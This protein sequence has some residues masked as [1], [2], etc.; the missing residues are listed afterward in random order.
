MKWRG[1][2]GLKYKLN[3]ESGRL[4]KSLKSFYLRNTTE[5]AAVIF[6]NV[7]KKKILS[8]FIF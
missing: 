1:R 8:D 6:I 4:G 7:K 3:H 5:K 2:R